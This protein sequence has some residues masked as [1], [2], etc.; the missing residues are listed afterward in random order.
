MTL[1]HELLLAKVGRFYER[2]E[3]PRH[4]RAHFNVF[5]TLRRSSDEVNL[6]SRF[7]HALLEHRT[8]DQRKNLRDFLRDV[9][10]VEG[11]GWKDAVVG[12]EVENIDLLIDDPKRRTAVIIENKI[13]AEDQDRQLLRY[14]EN[15]VAR[16][17]SPDAIHFVYL[18]PFGDPPSEQSVGNLGY[19]AVSYR[20]DLPRWLKKCQRRAFDVPA[21]RDSIAQYRQL[22]RTITGNDYSDEYMKELK[23]LCLASDNL[24]LAHDLSHAVI[25]A[26][27]ALI[28][29][30][31]CVIKQELAAVD[32]L[33]K[34]VADQQD[35]TKEN[36]VRDYITGKHGTASR[37]DY[38]IAEGASLVVAADEPHFWFGVSCDKAKHPELYSRLSEALSEMPG[39][40]DQWDPWYRYLP[41]TPNLRNLDHSGL[42]LLMSEDSQSKLAENISCSVA[43]VWRR[44]PSDVLEARRE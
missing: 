26:K 15:L 17:Y 4:R 1:A 44:V 38:R 11:F 21:L 34:R 2:H 22:I 8:D 29:R 25:G 12:R 41:E 3:A 36:A 30:L 23:K 5:S 14:H 37:L 6:H 35:R 7:L 10:E 33:L 19:K 42:R 32:P 28:V 43:E 31:W 16:G 20:D 27:V 13:W 24:I 39:Q 9:A 40:S 18:T